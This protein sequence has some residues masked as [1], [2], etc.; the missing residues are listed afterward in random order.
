MPT[1]NNVTIIM[2]EHA[3]KANR[4]SFL[5]GG[6]AIGGM[7]LLN[8]QKAL[9]TGNDRQD[10]GLKILAG[11]YLQTNFG[12]SISI[13]WI[14]NKNAASWVEYGTSAENQDQKAFGKSELGLKPAGRIN[15]VTL[16]H[17]KPGATYYYKIVSKEIKDFQPYKLTYGETV[18]GA[19]ASFIN[20]D[21]AKDSVSFVMLNDIHDRPR[22]IP[23]L[24]N[25]DKGNQ[26]DFVFFNG[27][28]FDYQT[29]EQQIIDH[30]LQPC[31]DL[32]AKNLPFIYVRGNHETRGKFARDFSAYF[33]HVGHAAFTLGP[34]R[35]VILDTG[36]DKEDT[37]PV[38]AGIVDFDVYRQEQARWLE[39]EIRS[40]AF[41]SAPF[42]IVMM[43]IPPRYSG[44][45]HGAVH[46]TEVFEPLLNKGK[47]D[48]V[49]SGHTHR[50]KVHAPDKQA[51]HYPIIIGGGPQEGTRT[52]TRVTATKKEIRVSMLDDSGKEVGSY[53]VSKK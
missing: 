9:A 43:H 35:F 2:K 38:Y 18:T 36:E 4:R 7:A 29:D 5:K 46:C 24:L 49:L 52:I 1:I 10:E 12:N 40:K 20:T 15:C 3:L 27:D 17:L 21:T 11:P 34:V 48:L 33:Q 39:Q 23:H 47:V 25:L 31:T 37:H 14:T 8:P 16:D 6:L 53:L 50:Y 22:S 13:L 42:R 51:N 19:P 26:K 44:N 32:F 30:M 41:K 28:V 45:A